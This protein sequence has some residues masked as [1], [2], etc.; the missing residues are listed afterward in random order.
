[1]LL[2]LLVVVMGGLG[3]GAKHNPLIGVLYVASN[4]TMYQSKMYISLLTTLQIPDFCCHFYDGRNSA[5]WM[6]EKD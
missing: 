5:N 2:L 3:I 1:M 6:L 4:D